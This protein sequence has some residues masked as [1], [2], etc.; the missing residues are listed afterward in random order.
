MLISDTLI[1]VAKNHAKN[2]KARFWAKVAKRD[3]GCWEWT[4]KINNY[5]YGI[6]FI[7]GKEIPAHRAAYIWTKGEIPAGM[8]IDHLCR[9]RKCVNPDHLEVVTNAENVLRGLSPFAQKKRQTHCIRGHLLD[10]QNLRIRSNGTRFCR[11]C[12]R[13]RA[14]ERRK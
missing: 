9:N 11:E 5:G 8:V 4:G 3:S 2:L 10:G 1:E 7:A 13:G 14:R 6:C 12:D